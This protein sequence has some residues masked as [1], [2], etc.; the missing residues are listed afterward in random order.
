MPK[1]KKLGNTIRGEGEYITKD[2]GK[3][4]DFA[5]GMRRDVSD[6]KPQ[7]DL[8]WRPGI[9]RLAQ[10]MGRGAKKYGKHN[11]MKASGQEEF[12]RF[13]ESALRHMFQWMDGETDEDHMAAVIFNLFGAEYVKQKLN[14]TK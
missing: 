4:L 7:Y 6:D 11:W 3:R 10:L 8:V 1:I 12:D 9:K 14:E 13:R 2:S 5:S